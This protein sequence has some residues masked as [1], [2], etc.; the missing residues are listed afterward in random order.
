MVNLITVTLMLLIG[1]LYEILTVIVYKLKFNY[2]GKIC[3]N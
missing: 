2:K 1:L 3:L